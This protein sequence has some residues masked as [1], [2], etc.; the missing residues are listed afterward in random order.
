MRDLIKEAVNSLDACLELRREVIKR[1][2]RGKLSEGDIV[3]VVDQVDDLSIEDIQ[4]LGSNFRRFPLG[5]DVVEIGVGPC[6][7][8]LTLREL[9]ENCIFTDHIGFPL[10]ICAYA[11]VDIGEREG[12]SPLEIFKRIYE[13][14]KVPI[15]LDHFGMYG[16]MK[17]PREI[18]HCYGECYYLGGPFKEC[19]KGR[20]HERLI[21]EE[22]KYSHQ[23]HQWIELASTVCINVVEEQG[24]KGHAP[25]LE[26]MKVVAEACKK[27]GK[28]LEGIFHIGDGYE[29]LIEGIKSCIQL[30]V[31]VFVIEGAPFNC[32]R[33]RLKAFAKA[34]AVSR[35]LVKGGVVGTNGAYEDECRI[36]L[37]SGLNLILS[38]F[39]D[40]HHG[41]MCGYSPGCAKRGNFGL[42]RV[43]SI[44]KEEIERLNTRLMDI[45]LSKALVRGCKF[46]HYRGRSMFYPNTLGGF[47]IGDAH[48]L[49]FKNSN[50]YR[51]ERYNKSLEDIERVDRLGLLGGRYIAWGMSKVLEPE[52]VY[53]S[54]P[55]PWVERAT[56]RILRDAG[57]EV[58][59]CKGK[60]EE[61]LKN[62]DK[63]YIT[64]FIPEIILKIIGKFKGEKNL[65]SLI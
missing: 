13:K 23:F 41:Y 20:I 62:A 21:E 29:D 55:D 61:V 22:R 7:S 53:I 27:Y 9:L 44:V 58:Y 31:D 5:C 14:V 10:H 25:P 3:E 42:P 8:S 15:D 50:L 30:D 12:M 26:E 43:L 33:D 49:A 60:D 6:A 59:R 57:I 37:R 16:P 45:N 28:G 19:P 35:I 40:N 64:S 47:F 32:A 36:G 34:V 24:G 1:I 11:L 65:E 4:K 63:T 54:D 46:L 48:W 17:F 2:V 52:E 18:T 38:G 39:S 56:V 51:M